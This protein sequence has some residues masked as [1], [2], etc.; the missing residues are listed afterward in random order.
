MVG[1]AADEARQRLGTLSLRTTPLIRPSTI[2][3]HGRQ[4]EIQG[5]SWT[6]LLIYGRLHFPLQLTL[7]ELLILAHYHLKLLSLMEQRLKVAHLVEVLPVLLV[8]VLLLGHV[9]GRRRRGQVLQDR[10]GGGRLQ[11]AHLGLGRRNLHGRE[12]F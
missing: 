8:H 2:V 6:L 10:L 7:Q 1:A 3:L 11:G 9:D 5:V 4:A 12:R